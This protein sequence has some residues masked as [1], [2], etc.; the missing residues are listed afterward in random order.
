MNASV[1]N[2]SSSQIAARLS[3]GYR[4]LAA[5]LGMTLG[6]ALA[7]VGVSVV[8]VLPLWLLATR[9]PTL[10]SAVI[11]IAIAGFLLFL[12]I[13]AVRIDG[14]RRLRALAA[15]GALVLSAIAAGYAVAALIAAGNMLA[16]LPS[17]I[18]LLLAIGFFCGAPRA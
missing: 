11:G 10:Y 15:R 14:A 13:R 1:S 8:I 5:F 12:L 4:R 17:A 16:G 6:V 3:A 2:V 9:F 7:A 18:I